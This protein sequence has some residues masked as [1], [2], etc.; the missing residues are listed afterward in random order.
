MKTLIKLILA[1]FTGIGLI[2]IY[3]F[4]TEAEWNEEEDHDFHNEDEYPLFV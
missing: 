3:N 1:L 4:A 2:K